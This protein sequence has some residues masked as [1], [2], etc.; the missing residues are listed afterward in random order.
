MQNCLG[1]GQ[2]LLQRRV[3]GLPG[4]D[5]QFFGLKLRQSAGQET[6]GQI[7]H[8]NAPGSLGAR[9]AFLQPSDILT[10]RARDCKTY[11]PGHLVMHRRHGVPGLGAGV[12]CNKPAMKAI[13]ILRQGC[14]RGGK[15]QMNL[16]RVAPQPHMV[17]ASARRGSD[18]FCAGKGVQHGG[19][20]FRWN[21]RLHPVRR[22]QDQYRAIRRQIVHAGERDGTNFG[23]GHFGLHLLDRDAALHQPRWPAP[24]RP[25]ARGHWGPVRGRRR[26]RWMPLWPP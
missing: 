6:K 15:P 7:G 19:H 9:A 17:A 13:A 12:A 22:A 11:P 3:V 8:R 14:P 25:A 24:P 20:V 5:K 4:F 21:I 18:S 10:I 16:A 2:Y 1:Y 23:W 26:D